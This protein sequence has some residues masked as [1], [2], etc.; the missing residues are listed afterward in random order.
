MVKN[1]YEA[2]NLS[3]AKDMSCIKFLFFLIFGFIVGV[4]IFVYLHFG[5]TGQRFANMHLDQWLMAL[6]TFVIAIFTVT[7]SEIQKQMVTLSSKMADI[8]TIS[9]K[10]DKV[11]LETELRPY[12]IIQLHSGVNE[13]LRKDGNS[14]LYWDSLYEKI[15]LV[16]PFKIRNVGKIPAIN[17]KAEYVSPTQKTSFLL[18]ERAN[19]IPPDT[20]TSE[21]FRP[22]INISSVLNDDK[23]F[24]V[25]LRIR[26]KG[27]DEIDPR[28][29]YSLLTLLVVKRIDGVYDIK[30]SNFK[31]GIEEI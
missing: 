31:F 29:Y 8:A 28:T 26:Y 12:L 18:G 16:L 5:N 2:I 4:L 25:N 27:N 15:F 24:E 3:I 19:N 13:Y 22:H 17:I 14:Q 23:E 1:R 20:E 6:S 9:A 21:T 30:D 10:Q 11:R 7:S